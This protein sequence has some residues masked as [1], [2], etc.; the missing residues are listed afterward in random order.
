[1]IDLAKRHLPSF[2]DVEVEEQEDFLALELKWNS[3]FWVEHAIG[4]IGYPDD[5][6]NEEELLNSA[7]GSVP[8]GFGN[9]SFRKIH[10]GFHPTNHPNQESTHVERMSMRKPKI[11]PI[12]RWILETM[13]PYIEAAKCKTLDQFIGGETQ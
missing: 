7:R 13:T 5:T 9:W 4:K 8:L 11:Y 10:C 1:L 2:I 6:K 12:K 3:N